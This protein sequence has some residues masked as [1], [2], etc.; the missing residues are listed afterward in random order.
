MYDENNNTKLFFSLGKC[1]KYLRAKGFP[2]TQTTLVKYVNI[3]KN[4]YG[5]KFKYV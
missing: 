5:Y 2:A 4:Y 1:I 3:D